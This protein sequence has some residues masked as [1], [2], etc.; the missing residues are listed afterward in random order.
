LNAEQPYIL[1]AEDDPDD[2]DAFS[3]AFMRL[4]PEVPLKIVQD[5]QELLDFLDACPDARLP[6]IIVL[7]YKMPKLTGAD[8][9][10]YL[11]VCRRFN[12][13][14]KIV[15]ST[16]AREKDITECLQLGAANYFTKP[17]TNQELEDFIVGI[18]AFVY[19]QSRNM[20]D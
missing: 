2:Q 12:H 9:L 16:S 13:I 15:W 14:P 6:A 10:R 5:G 3:E 8:V 7:D 17:A 1:L 4:N 20:Q 18:N 11:A 19:R